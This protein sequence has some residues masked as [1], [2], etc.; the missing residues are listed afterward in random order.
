MINVPQSRNA[1]RHRT[2]RL[3]YPTPHGCMRQTVQVREVQ[4]LMEGFVIEAW[5]SSTDH[6]PASGGAETKMKRPVRLLGRAAPNPKLLSNPFGSLGN[7]KLK[8]RISTGEPTNTLNSTMTLANK[9]RRQNPNS[10]HT[11]VGHGDNTS[12]E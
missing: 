9:F 10:I 5:R 4:S 2:W 3:E 11:P 12:P 6:A 1:V 8:S 7:S